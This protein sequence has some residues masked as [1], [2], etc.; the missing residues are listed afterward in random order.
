MYA[1]VSISRLLL[2]LEFDPL[3]MAYSS[4]DLNEPEVIQPSLSWISNEYDVSLPNGDYFPSDGT[5]YA[6]PFFNSSGYH[7]EGLLRAL[8]PLLCMQ[9]DEPFFA[10]SS[11]DELSESEEAYGGEDW[12]RQCDSVFSYSWQDNYCSPENEIK[13][14]LEKAE[15]LNPSEEQC[16]S[17]FACEDEDSESYPAASDYDPWSFCAS[18]L[19]YGDEKIASDYGLEENDIAYDQ[20]MR[21]VAVYEGIFGYWPCLY[22][23]NSRTRFTLEEW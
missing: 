23:R 9:E 10:S 8:M 22:Q 13:D 21:E 15:C 5:I 16:E 3:E 19:G 20:R 6:S 11:W 2:K 1:G 18:W 14:S 7:Q 17:G 12:L 4:F